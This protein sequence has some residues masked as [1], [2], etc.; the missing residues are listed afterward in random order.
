MW[1]CSVG[2]SN[3]RRASRTASLA[4][5]F[6]RHN[7]CG[8][9]LFRALSSAPTCESL[10]TPAWTQV[11]RRRYFENTQDIKKRKAAARFKK[12]FR[13][14]ALRARRHSYAV[15]LNQFSTCSLPPRSLLCR[16]F[17]RPKALEMSESIA[18][19]KSTKAPVVAP[20]AP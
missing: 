11:K 1:P 7:S 17:T 12:V 5:L 9:L 13:Y 8:S 18:L 14:A 3:A 2:D 10:T 16:R 15:F 4:G 20:P 19:G 6:G